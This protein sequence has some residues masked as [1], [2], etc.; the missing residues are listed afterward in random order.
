MV[1]DTADGASGTDHRRAVPAPRVSRRK[2]LAAVPTVLLERRQDVALAF[3]TCCLGLVPIA[4]LP[5]ENSIYAGIATATPTV[6]TYTIAA[7]LA[8]GVLATVAPRRFLSGL[9]PWAPLFAWFILLSILTWEGSGRAVSG[10][11]HLELAALVFAVGAAARGYER[12]RLGGPFLSWAFAVVAWIQLIAI[13]MAAIG[14]PLRRIEG[15]QALDVLGR[16]TGLTAHPGELA[17]LLFFCGLCALTLPQR[18]RRERWAAWCTLGAV[19]LGISLAQSRTALVATMSMI[20]IFVLLELTAGRWQRRHFVVLGITIVLGALSLPWLI[21]RFSA[22]PS[23][24]ARQHVA[25][26]AFSVIRDHPLAGVGPNNYVAVVGKLDALTE[27]GVPVHNIFLLSAAELGV[28]GAALLWLPF[29]MVTARS[30]GR[31]WRTR[32]TDLDA[33]VIV[34]ALP[35]V[36]LIAMTG[37]GLL[38]GPYF[39]M[40]A[41][42]FGYFGVKARSD[43]P[44]VGDGRR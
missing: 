3:L 31:V 1:A 14:F 40:F 6:Y 2:R 4:L 15:A 44:G 34:S 11:L 19:L 29:A 12:D 38:Q 26:V 33:R 23:G 37:W 21:E 20:F 32:G 18:S 35:G 43:T 16:A 22:D 13:A 36:V 17:K 25:R 8:G 9:L 24:G 42:V 28:L 39:L 30:L 7:V 27:T 41:L 5:T 10:V